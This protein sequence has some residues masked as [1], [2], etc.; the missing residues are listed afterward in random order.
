M[1]TEGIRTIIGSNLRPGVRP[2]GF[3]H[4]FGPSSA[5]SRK[6]RATMQEVKNAAEEALARRGLQNAPDSLVGR[7]A[8]PPSP[9]V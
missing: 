8:L 1:S 5:K 4:H 2:G 7:Q 3:S 9:S 6:K